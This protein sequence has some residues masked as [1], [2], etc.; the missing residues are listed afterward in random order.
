[1]L[2][3][4]HP[5]EDYWFYDPVIY[6]LD[7]DVFKIIE[8]SCTDES[9]KIRIKND[10]TNDG[11]VYTTTMFM[12]GDMKLKLNIPTVPTTGDS[13]TFGFYSSSEGNQNSAYFFISGEDFSVR[14]YD[15]VNATVEETA[16]EWDSDWTAATAIYEIRWHMDSVRFYING[17]QKAV[18]SLNKPKQVLMPLYIFNNKADNMD[19]SYIRVSGSRKIYFAKEHG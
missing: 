11:T 3:K 2:S 9:G 5:S 1:M 16:I 12:M 8:G 10:T 6:G 19:L 13:R 15:A 14:T 4:V 18:H 17:V 7:L